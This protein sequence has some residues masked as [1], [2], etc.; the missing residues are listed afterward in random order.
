VPASQSTQRSLLS[1][2]TYALANAAQRGLAF[3]LLPLYTTVLSSSEYGRLGLLLTLQT[4]AIVVFS[5]GMENGLI[6]QFFQIEG[7]PL[8]Q[9]RL[10]ITAWNFLALASLGL[11]ATAAFLL[12]ALA[13]TTPA[14]NPAEG[15]LAVVSAATL[16]GAT[17]VPLTVLRVEQRL[18]DYIILTAIIGSSTS[19]LSILFVV[20]LR[21]GVSGWIGAVLLANALALIA[22]LFIIPWGRIDK[23]DG[24]GLLAV[25]KIGIPLVPHSASGWSLQ[26]ADRIILASLVAVNSLGVYT[27]AANL[28][29]PV[30]VLLQGLN[31]GFIPSYARTRN[32]AGAVRDLRDTVTIQVVLTLVIGCLA[33]LLGPP[34]VSFLSH[35]YSGATT[36][37]PWLVLGYVFLGIYMIPMN[38]ISMVLGRTTFVWVFT[39]CAAAIN[40]GA[41]YLLVPDYGILGAAEASAIGY[42]ALVILISAYAKVIRI[43]STIDWKRLVPM[44]ITVTITF[45]IGAAL[46]PGEG[47]AGLLSRTVLLLTLPLTLALAAGIRRPEIAAYGQQFWSRIRPS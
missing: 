23:L 21:L 29:L 47:L 4:G 11:A 18:R 25:L 3:V 44:T 19:I 26:L 46:L 41:I 34:F 37:I 40:I 28:A 45:I 24:R 14:F 39:F 27:L 8:A 16:V 9:R 31:L 33:A 7:D 5:A 32:Q 2:S 15:A 20:V 1:G 30:L 6:R 10:I 36:S 35:A 17:V 42:F 22:G 12:L 43:N 13:P 38:F